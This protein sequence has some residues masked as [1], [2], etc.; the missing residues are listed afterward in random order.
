MLADGPAEAGAEGATDGPAAPLEVGA[1]VAGAVG[2]GV[3]DG[4]QAARRRM[5]ARNEADG[6]MAART[7]GWSMR[8][9]VP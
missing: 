4:P 2:L 6:R 3:V 7:V 5:S 9:I 8:G 1:G